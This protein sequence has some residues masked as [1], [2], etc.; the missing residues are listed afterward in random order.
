MGPH[1]GTGLD[2]DEQPL[3][4][5]L[6]PGMQEKVSPFP[7]AIAR[8]FTQLIEARGV[9]QVNLSCVQLIHRPRLRCE[10]IQFTRWFG[11]KLSASPTLLNPSSR[12]M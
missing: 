8:R 4:L 6:M 9:H 2:R 12:S 11:S 1:I 3:N 7:R 10:I 5:V